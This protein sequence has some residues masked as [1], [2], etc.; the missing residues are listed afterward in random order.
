MEGYDKFM[1]EIRPITAADIDAVAV[2][3]VR[4]WQAG[5]AGIMPAGFLA[6]LDPAVFAEQRRT[7]TPPPGAA[8]LV[9]VDDGV[10]I[11]FASFGPDLTGDPEIAQLYALYVDPDHWDTGTGWALLQAARAAM[12]RDGWTAMR[13][14]VLEDNH[15]AR[16]FYERAGLAPD[17]ARDIFTPHGTAV[18]LPDI[19]Y[20]GRL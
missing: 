17:G 15:R 10:I 8:T 3:H 2:V 20:S 13:L 5:Y 11:G 12:G 4:T 9:A 14:W 1:T 19:R 7:R 18:E 6:A 16:R